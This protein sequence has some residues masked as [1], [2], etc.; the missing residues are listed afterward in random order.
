M[1]LQKNI[2]C[3]PVQSP[4]H[5]GCLTHLSPRYVRLSVASAG[6]RGSHAPRVVTR[7]SL[8]HKDIGTGA[9]LGFAAAAIVLLHQRERER[10]PLFFAGLL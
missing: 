6:T 9:W 4:A 7:S 3:L 1:L 2:V 10:E 8:S 5:L